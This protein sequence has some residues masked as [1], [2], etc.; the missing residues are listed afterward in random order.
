MTESEAEDGP[1]S[2][3]CCAACSPPVQRPTYACLQ[4]TVAV[5]VLDDLADPDFVFMPVGGE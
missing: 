5:E 2:R 4:G 1:A 3:A